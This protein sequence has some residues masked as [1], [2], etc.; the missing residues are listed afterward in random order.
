MWPDNR[1]PFLIQAFTNST[2]TTTDSWWCSF[3]QKHSTFSS[4]V[5]RNWLSGKRIVVR[6]RWRLTKWFFWKGITSKKLK[7]LL[8][9]FLVVSSSLFSSIFPRVKFSI[10]PG[11][12]GGRM[13]IPM[14]MFIVSV[15]ASLTFWLLLLLSLFLLMLLSLFW[16][17]LLETRPMRL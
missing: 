5:L 1:V 15:V 8:C 12:R 2:M 17:P 13:T 4:S 9:L 6:I 7:P 10:L 3:V 16:F 14:F 11:G